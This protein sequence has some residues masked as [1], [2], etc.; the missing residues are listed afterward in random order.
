MVRYY[1]KKQNEN[2]NYSK[3]DLNQALEEVKG[4]RMTVNKA[5]KLYNIPYPTIYTNLKRTRGAKKSFKGRLTALSRQEEELTNGIATLQKWGFGLSRKE[6]IEL[7][8]QYVRD[9]NLH[10][11]FTWH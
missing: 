4:G 9:N 11:P 7:V 8:G 2:H 6:I 3:D 5:S 10:T 1:R